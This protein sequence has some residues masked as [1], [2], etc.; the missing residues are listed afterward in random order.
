[1]AADFDSINRSAFAIVL[2]VAAAGSCWLSGSLA[3]PFAPPLHAA[4][5]LPETPDTPAPG[6][7]VQPA[8]PGNP[9]HGADIA[10]Q[11]CSMCH[12]V[13]K[14]A[15]DTVGPGL[16]GVTTR[17]IGAKPGYSYSEALSSHG[18]SWNDA[19]LSA[20]LRNPAAFAPGTRMSFPGL[21]NPADRADVIAWLNTLK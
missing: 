14:D 5:P 8:A 15:P 16:F 2:A 19:T 3:V 18:G 7:P 4:I 13:A 9:A 1:M 11:A 17:K 12:M 21:E 20:W 6:T 10:Q